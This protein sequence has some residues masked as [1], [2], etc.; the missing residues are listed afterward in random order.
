MEKPPVKIKAVWHTF[1]YDNDKKD[2]A[3]MPIDEA[4]LDGK[5]CP[6]SYVIHYGQGNVRKVLKKFNRIGNPTTR[7]TLYYGYTS[8]NKITFTIIP[9]N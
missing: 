7:W 1:G 4:I 2:F 5:D 3:F 9:K 6:R 8:R